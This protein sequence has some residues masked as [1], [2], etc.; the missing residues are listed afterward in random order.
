[1]CYPHAVKLAQRLCLIAALMLLRAASL[2]AAP[3]SAAPLSAAAPAPAELYPEITPFRT[4]YLK[5][6]ALHE[7]YCELAG[8]PRGAPV[9]VLHGGPGG[10]SS[11]SLRRFH[12]PKK[13]LIVI[14]DQRGAGKSR[15]PHRRGPAHARRARRGDALA[16]A[17]GR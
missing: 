17:A 1:M 9:M 14:A 11:P 5:V 2:A 3:L 13:W 12:D 10:G 7:I 8:N 16:G 6:S 4:G 15:G